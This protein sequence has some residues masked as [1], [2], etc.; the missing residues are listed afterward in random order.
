MAQAI[1]YLE[2]LLEDEGPFAG[3]FGFSQGAALTLSYFYRQQ[4][5]TG[6]LRVKFACLFSAAIPCSPDAGVGDTIISSLR[7]L[8]LDITDRAGCNSEDLTMA[9]KEFIDVLQHTV[10]EA[11]AHDP[12][13]PWIDMDVY[14]YGERDSIPRVMYPSLLAQKIRIPTIHVWGQNDF[15]YMVR[16]AEVAHSICDESMAKTVLHAGLHDIPKRQVEIKAVLRKI[17]WAIYHM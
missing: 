15:E 2:E 17:D 9:E 5:A 4:A 1:D 14:R 11:A 7:A 3:I 12:L 10:V 8:E 13:F 6:P 16:M